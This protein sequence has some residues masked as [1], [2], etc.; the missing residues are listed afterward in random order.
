MVLRTARLCLRCLEEGAVACHRDLLEESLASRRTGWPGGVVRRGQA[1]LGGWRGREQ[2]TMAGMETRNRWEDGR[3]GRWRRKGE[4]GNALSHSHRDTPSLCNLLFFDAV[5]RRIETC[6]PLFFSQNMF[7]AMSQP[8]I[9]QQGT[10]EASQQAPC[11]TLPPGSGAR[12][13]ARPWW[14]HGQF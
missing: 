9:A 1:K 5:P 13:D 8:D 14:P 7:S 10:A 11:K 12:A 6:F 3:G 4:R 2:A